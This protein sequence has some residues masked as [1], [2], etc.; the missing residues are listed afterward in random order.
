[1]LSNI[2]SSSC[3][4]TSPS[5]VQ[6]RGLTSSTIPYSTCTNCSQ[7]H[8]ARCSVVRVIRLDHSRMKKIFLEGFTEIMRRRRRVGVDWEGLSLG[9]GCPLPGRLRGLRER[10]ELHQPQ[11]SF[12]RDMERFG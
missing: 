8:T 1:M 9:R 7:L 5:V 3:R 6:F 4:S 12:L 11:M 10:Q 2:F